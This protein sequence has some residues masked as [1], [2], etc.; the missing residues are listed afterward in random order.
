MDEC[1]LVWHCDRSSDFVLTLS[2]LELVIQGLANRLIEIGQ[3]YPCRRNSTAA[4]ISVALS[5]DLVSI[6]VVNLHIFTHLVGGEVLTFMT[7]AR[8]VDSDRGLFSP[9]NEGVVG[10]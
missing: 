3:I 5:S 8:D 6:E 7:M 1:L 10:G 4:T 2:V 9:H